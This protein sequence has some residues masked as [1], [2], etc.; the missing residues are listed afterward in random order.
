M[1]KAP[2][3]PQS[4]EEWQQAVDVAQFLL[5][6]ESCRMY[7]VSRS[8]GDEVARKTITAPGAG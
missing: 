3:D 6:L 4:P 5:D 7:G 1:K 2:R 8:N